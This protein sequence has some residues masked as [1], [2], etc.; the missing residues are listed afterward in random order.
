MVSYQD[1]SGSKRPMSLLSR[2]RLDCQVFPLGA[3]WRGK[4]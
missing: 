4:D 1:V 3:G 2:L